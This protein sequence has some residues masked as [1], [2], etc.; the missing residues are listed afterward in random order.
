ML[1]YLTPNTIP[2]D[3]VCRTMYIPN[4]PDLIAVVLGVF[5]PLLDPA[6]WT[7]YGTKT[8]EETARGLIDMYDNFSFGLGSCRMIGELIFYAGPTSPDAKWLLC[9][10]ASLLR[11]DYSDLFTVIGTTYGAVDS[12][13]FNLPDFRSRIPLMAGTGSGLSTYALGD[14]VGEETHTLVTSEV[15]SH[16][17]TD[18]GHTHVEGNATPSVGAAITGV[19]V[20]SAIPSIGVTG[21][22]SA[23]LTSSGGDGAHNNIQPILACN[24]LI[25]ALP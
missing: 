13:H 4:D 23:A 3:T 10:G 7:K 15:P 25:V 12:M 18:A 16:T 24:V 17:H 21:S 20:P 22:G 1:G 19:P 5:L 2:A 14:A 11:A 6:S 8:P 9:D